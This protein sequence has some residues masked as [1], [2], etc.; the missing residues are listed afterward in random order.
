MI[1]IDLTLTG[2]TGSSATANQTSQLSSLSA[3]SFTE[4]LSEAFSETLS[5][6]GINPS[7]IQL[8]FQDEPSQTSAASQTPAASATPATIQTPVATQTATASQA[9]AASAATVASLTSA[10]SLISATAVAP[11][12]TSTPTIASTPATASST[13]SSSQTWYA[14]TPADD[15]YW[16]AQPAA[17]QQLRGIQ[18]INERKDL[19]EQLASEGYS[20]DVP[21]MVWG[22]DAGKVTA[23][24]ESYGYTWVPSALQQPVAAAPGITGGGITP[25]D[26]NNPPSGSIQVPPAQ[27]S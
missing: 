13:G 27:N 10:A 3:Q 5:K 17:V 23:A 24:R 11:P 26:P 16:A 18:D 19:G 22:W 7:S 4:L 9:P 15:A 1:N 21:I 25:Y 12:T 8:S 20:I 2:I 6:L 14:S